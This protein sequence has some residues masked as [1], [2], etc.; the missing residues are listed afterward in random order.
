MQDPSMLSDAFAPLNTSDIALNK[1]A[2]VLAYDVR[3]IVLYTRQ[4]SS[5]E[6]LTMHVRQLEMQPVLQVEAQV[7]PMLVT[8]GKEQAS[9]ASPAAVELQ[10]AAALPK[11]CIAVKAVDDLTLLLVN[12]LQQLGALCSEQTRKST[13]IS[14]TQISNRYK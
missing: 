6:L 2:E 11:L 10:F 5:F 14:G 9:H 8:F 1:V 12:L 7:L 4:V 13:V 3:N